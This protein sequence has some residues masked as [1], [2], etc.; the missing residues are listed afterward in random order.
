[1]KQKAIQETDFKRIKEWEGNESVEDDIVVFDRMGEAPIPHEPRRMNFILVG[2]CT[3]GTIHYELDT[4]EQNVGQGDCIIVTDRHVI[5]NYHHSDDM[6][7]LGLMVSPKFFYETIRNATDV[8]SMLLLSRNHPVIHLTEHETDIFTEYFYMIK[9][10][11]ADASNRFRRELIHTLLVAMFYDLSNAIFRLQAADNSHKTRAD[12]IFARFIKLLED[13]YTS[14]RRVG[15]YADQL[16]ITPKYLSETVKQVS[17]CTPN[18]WIDRYVTLEIRVLLK[19]TTKSIKEIARQLNFPNQ[20][21]LG[22][23]FKEHVGVSPSEYRQR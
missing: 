10:K 15:W 7:G 16:C 20:S 1:M 22:K 21:F 3:Q 13:H 6:Q 12:I 4:Q 17:R 23:Y 18:E 5:D 11:M 2:L 14:E 9:K 19:N 8:S